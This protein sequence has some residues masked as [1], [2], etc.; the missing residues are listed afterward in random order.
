M[1]WWSESSGKLSEADLKLLKLSCG[2]VLSLKIDPVHGG[3]RAGETWGRSKSK[4][5][6]WLIVTGLVARDDT[7]SE[8][9]TP[10]TTEHVEQPFPS[11]GSG[12]RWGVSSPS[13]GSNHAG[14]QAHGLAANQQGRGRI[15]SRVGPG[16]KPAAHAGYQDNWAMPGLIPHRAAT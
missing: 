16:I 1:E 3:A 6:C 8:G 2:W 14:Q 7:L 9:R 4:N 5:S 13:S 15:P 11:P 12:L 10:S